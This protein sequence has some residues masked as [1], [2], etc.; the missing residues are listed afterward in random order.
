MTHDDNLNGLAVLKRDGRGRIR[1]TPEQ[2][3]EAV[4]QFE[5]SGLSGP[6][7]CRVAGIHYQTFVGWR[8]EARSRSARQGVKP[9]PAAAIEPTAIRLMEVAP[10]LAPVSS[11]LQVALPGGARLLV[12]DIAQATL[13]AHLIT[14]LNPTSTAPC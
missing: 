7:F 2:R 12:A 14:A 4:E 13:A 11:P 9:R 5:R 3:R 1:S 6:A 10:A 8:K